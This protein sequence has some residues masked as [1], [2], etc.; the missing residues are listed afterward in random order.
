[1]SDPYET[2]GKIRRNL[3][4]IRN[5]WDA[6][7]TLVHRQMSD[8][9][10]TGSATSPALVPTHVLDARADC[11]HD[12]RFF[13]GLILDQV[14]GG[15]IHTRVDATNVPNLTRFI[16][17]WALLFAE[18]MPDDADQCARDMRGHAER[19]TGMIRGDQLHRYQ[20]GRCP[21]LVGEEQT[22]LCPGN[23]WASMSIVA[24]RTRCC[25]SRSSADQ[26]A[27]LLSEGHAWADPWQ[28][29]ALGKRL[30]VPA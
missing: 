19:M 6:T 11:H 25:R 27:G 28:W 8:E 29:A 16:D 13:T 14:N 21:E 23:L 5:V 15:T 18:Q 24:T 10:V 1:M 12:L 7:I 30:E 3:V 17:T 9:P 22:Q 2:A 20:V 26:D 4:T